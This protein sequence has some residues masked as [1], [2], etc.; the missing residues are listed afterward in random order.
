MTQSKLIAQRYQVTKRL[1]SG[2]FGDTFLAQDLYSPSQ[3]RCVIKQLRRIDD[4][5]S[6]YE[7]VK[8]RFNREALILE[9][10]GEN[11]SHI[12]S[13]YAYFEEEGLFYLV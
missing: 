3:K 6:S 7:L 13:L 11:Y 9:S 4:D 2:G 1:G 10:L 5:P 8:E 12:P